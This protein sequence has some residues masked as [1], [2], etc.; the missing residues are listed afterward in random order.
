MTRVLVVTSGDLHGAPL[1]S[2][3]RALEL[4]RTLRDHGE[5]TLAVAGD[6][7]TAVDGMPCVGFHPHDPLALAQPLRDADVV[8]C[9][10]RWPRVM[11]AI[12][13]SGA[14][15]VFDLYDPE[16]LAL[17]PGF[18]GQRPAVRRWVAEYSIDRVAEALRIGDHFLCSSERQRDLWLGMML[19]E[20]L[21]D[22]GR[23]DDDPS[24]RSLIDVVP[25]G[26]P[27]ERP[28]AQGQGP[29]ERFPALDREHEVVL[30]NGGLWP[31]L[32][33]ETPIRAVARLAERRPVRLVFMGAAGGLPAD[34]ATERAR[35]L[36]SRLG[37]LDRSVF[38]NDAW[39]PY[40]ERAAWLG[41]ADCAVSAHTD[42]METRFAF[43]TR[44]LDCL[45]SG[46]PI[47]C[48]EGDELAE[49][50]EREGLGA[51]VP[52]SDPH[53]LATALEQVLDR[54]RG[55]CEAAFQRVR[56]RFAWS[57]VS[58]PLVRMLAGPAPPPAPGR[59]V[60]RAEGLR[61][62]LYLSGRRALDTVGVRDW[63]R[64]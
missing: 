7:P 43:R 61:R 53:A 29:R 47:V 4:A 33:S 52:P 21:I 35:G 59:S 16:P 18:P 49:L 38:F 20:R 2:G 45:W 58:R 11:R 24:L 22:P 31:W 5:V 19:A 36:A 63:P 13:R 54:G 48:T 25:F 1:G 41:Q 39:V 28:A 51:A 62:A 34:R 40:A 10:P 30:W 6:A 8:L 12:R 9:T 46:L 57:E 23:S 37:V 26:I 50:V 44:L 32:D 55:G 42:S 17:I 14:R 60:G 64:L 56:P 15:L 3:I 27:E